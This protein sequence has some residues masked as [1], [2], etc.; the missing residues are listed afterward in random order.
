M[1]RFLLFL[2]IIFI[3][4]NLSAQVK[5]TYYDA[6][7]KPCDAAKAVYYGLVTKTDSGWLKEDYFIS[8]KR[9]QMKALYEDSTCKR[10]NGTCA[11]FY[12][13]GQL[14]TYGQMRH[15]KQE[16]V[17]VRYHS[18]GMMADSGFYREGKQVGYRLGWHPNGMISD[19]TALI[20]DSVSVRYGWFDNGTMSSGGYMLRDEPYQKWKYYNLL[21]ALTALVY[22]EKGKIVNKEYYN[23]DGTRLADTSDTEATFS[24]GGMPGWR[25][26]LQRSAVWPRGLRLVNT[27]RVTL[28]VSYTITQEGKVTDVELENPFHP[29][30]DRV[31]INVIR[32]SPKWVAARQYNRNVKQRLRQPLTFAQE[33]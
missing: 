28:L 8:T 32:D 33:E 30:I 16:G 26:Y 3:T 1:K 6:F 17:C 9:L 15:N 14:S 19:S 5:E 18:N 29:E 20:N 7:W 21:G 11:W 27:N 12:S 10:I 22:Y 4:G 23:T 31:A 25:K 24:K 2:S 13:N